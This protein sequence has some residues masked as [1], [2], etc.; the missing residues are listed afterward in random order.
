MV[1][2]CHLTLYAII[3][4]KKYFEVDK[5]RRLLTSLF[6]NKLYYASEIWHKPFLK[7]QLLYRLDS[8][9]SQALRKTFVTQIPTSFASI[10]S[11]TELHRTCYHAMPDKNN[12]IQTCPTAI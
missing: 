9:F 8:A 5:L 10:I 1:V 11:N 12:E 2:L 7:R 6:F 4:I 3:M